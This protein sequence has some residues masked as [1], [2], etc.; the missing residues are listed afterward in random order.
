M[1]EN[2]R[3]GCFIVAHPGRQPGALLAA[4]AFIIVTLCQDPNGNRASHW[5]AF[6]ASHAFPEMIFIHSQCE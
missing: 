5:A 2:I 3:Q 1:V 4:P 6:A